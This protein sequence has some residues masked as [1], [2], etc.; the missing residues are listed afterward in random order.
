MQFIELKDQRKA[1]IGMFE[2]IATLLVFFILLVFGLIFYSHYA[3][4]NAED[5]RSVQEDLASI[6]LVQKVSHLPELK[7]TKGDISIENCLDLLKLQ[8]FEDVVDER[9][10]YYFNIFSYSYIE[11]REIYPNNRTFVL[12]K[13]LINSTV[14]DHVP[15]DNVEGLV[16]DVPVSLFDPILKQYSM[17]YLK[18]IYIPFNK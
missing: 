5:A 1:Q 17:G 16:V 9:F 13:N 11:A 6:A 7:C 18:V 8:A 12:Y 15:V 14:R 2:T 4:Q 3:E 10:S